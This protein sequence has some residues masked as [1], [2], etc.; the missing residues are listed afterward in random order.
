VDRQGRNLGLGPVFF[1][2]VLT[3]CGLT[4]FAASSLF[5][6]FVILSLCFS[7]FFAF[8][9]RH[10]AFHVCCSLCGESARG[11]H[12]T[13]V[14]VASHTHQDAFVGDYC[15]ETNRALIT[16][17][18]TVSADESDFI[19]SPFQTTYCT[20]LGRNATAAALAASGRPYPPSRTGLVGSTSATSQVPDELALLKYLDG[21]TASGYDGVGDVCDCV[22]CTRLARGY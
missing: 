21:I 12:S 10:Q 20:P 8:P 13:V 16:N 4:L 1:L 3:C 15:G 2:T 14:N 9:V 18:E 11:V 6:M 5:T 17:F 22:C 19:T 7:L